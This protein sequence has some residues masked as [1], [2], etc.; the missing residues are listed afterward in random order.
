MK[1]RLLDL[2]P[3]PFIGAAGTVLTVAA[4]AVAVV[5]RPPSFGAPGFLPDCAL[6]LC[7]ILAVVLAYLF[8]ISVRNETKVYMNSVPLFMMASILPIP[9]AAISICLGKLTGE[10]ATRSRTGIYNSDISTQVSR[11]TLGGLAGTVV[12]HTGAGPGIHPLPLFGAALILWLGDTLTSPFLFCPATGESPAAVLH[13]VAVEAGPVEGAQYMFGILGAVAADE[14][15][16]TLLLLFIPSALMYLAFKHAKDVHEGA[17]LILAGVVDAAPEAVLVLDR[18]GRI[19]VA[20]RHAASL[21]GCATSN[22]VVGHTI[23]EA[24]VPDDRTRILS[25]T[26][27][28][29]EEG[30]ELPPREYVMTRADGTAFTAELSWTP[31]SDRR[32]NRTS[33]SAIARDV[34]RRKEAEEALAYRA[35]H[36]ALTDLPNRVLFHDRLSQALRDSRRNAHPFAVAL[37]DLDRFKQVNDTFGHRYGD[38]L[39]R[40]VSTRLQNALRDSDTIAR[41]GGDEFGVLLPKAGPEGAVIVATRLLDSLCVPFTVEG[42]V[43]EIGGSIGIA[44]YPDHGTEVETLLERADLAMYAIKR[45]RGG[46][47]L[48]SVPE[49]LSYSM[50]S[51]RSH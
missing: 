24:V 29:I 25:D 49:V 5:L 30:G 20:N 2:M 46:Y 15:R 33:V 36:D 23:D 31:V 3:Q 19:I 17:R 10:L 28:L 37:I 45:E 12:A 41:L 39:L 4:L 42:E 8:P 6:A 18:D 7:L 16:W 9:M 32:G 22:E 43:L 51:T 44:V 38:E 11:W 1:R 47:R 40:Q 26:R 34:S 27:F 13:T 48:W 14:A 50:P 35:M 21:Y